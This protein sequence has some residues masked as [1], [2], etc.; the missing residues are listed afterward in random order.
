MKREYIN[1]GI[2]GIAIVSICI[3]IMGAYTPG[4]QV[5]ANWAQSSP[6][7]PSFIQN[8][9]STLPWDTCANLRPLLYNSSG[10]LNQRPKFWFGTVSITDATQQSVDISSAG[11]SVVT[12]YMVSVNDDVYTHV[13]VR[14][15][16]TTAIT[17]DSYQLTTTGVSILSIP[18][19]QTVVQGAASDLTGLQVSVT[20][21]GY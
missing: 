18:V 14:T 8:K 5:Q 2:I 13:Q 11:F 21:M 4:S 16:S 1:H 7:A 12:G 17:L 10:L 9:P 3:T 15:I 20:I 6:A 19:I